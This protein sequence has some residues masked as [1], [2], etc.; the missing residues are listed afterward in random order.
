MWETRPACWAGFIN[1]SLSR[2][3]IGNTLLSIRYYSFVSFEAMTLYSKTLHCKR[4]VSFPSLQIG[5]FI[6]YE[7]WIA[8]W[9][10][11]GLDSG[12][13]PCC[14][15]GCVWVTEPHWTPT[16]ACNMWRLVSASCM[17]CALHA[18]IH[19]KH[20][21][22]GLVHSK[23]SMSGIC[24]FTPNEENLC[25]HTGCS[26]PLLTLFWGLLIGLGSG[27]GEPDAL[28]TLAFVMREWAPS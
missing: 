9:T 26:G 27:G 10:D 19:E 5:Q 16:C 7:H 23:C 8:S 22:Q 13:A 20:S 3:L 17:L 21:A 6:E 25:S 14:L 12:F 2:L 1:A 24:Y 4:S 18:I 15:N 11:L 28:D